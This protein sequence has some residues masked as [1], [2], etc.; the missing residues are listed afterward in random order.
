MGVLREE[1]AI[2]TTPLKVIMGGQ[3][4]V[5]KT[6]EL[7]RLHESLGSTKLNRRLFTA[8]GKTGF[9]FGSDI[10]IAGIGVKLANEFLTPQST[11]RKRASELIDKLNATPESEIRSDA[12]NVAS[13]SVARDVVKEMNLGNDRP[14]L[15]I[16]DGLEKYPAHGAAALLSALL[17]LPC[18]LV[19]VVPLPLLLSPDYAPTIAECDRVISLPAISLHRPDGNRDEAGIAL[20]RAVIERRA[21]TDTFESSALDAIIEASG[22]IHRDLLTLAQQSCM[23]AAMKNR[24]NVTEPDARA[25]IEE[26]RQELSFHLTPSDLA[27]LL[28]VKGSKRLTG[29]P[30]ALPLISRNLIVSYHG[31]WAWFDVHPL[32]LPLLATYEKMASAS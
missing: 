13:R 22:G 4:G 19:V 24:A 23:R 17:D 15:I 20:L 10:F 21:G 8:E 12:I 5:G 31:D 16:L 30:R 26:R 14:A 32:I 25:A 3:R 1:F 9:T 11:S 7:K 27:Y 6:T 29:D 2:R 28:E 18:S